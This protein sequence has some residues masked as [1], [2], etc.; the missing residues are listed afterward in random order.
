MN[1]ELLKELIEDI[2]TTH[3]DE[4]LKEAEED[5][6]DMYHESKIFKDILKKVKENISNNNKA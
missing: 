4:I 6:G 2:I 3:D 5:Y 1:E